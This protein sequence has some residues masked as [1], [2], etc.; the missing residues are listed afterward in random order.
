M[1]LMS[2]LYPNYSV[3]TKNPQHLG[4]LYG[5]G[6]AKANLKLLPPLLLPA[7]MET[8]PYGLIIFIGYMDFSVTENSGQLLHI[9]RPTILLKLADWQVKRVL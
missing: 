4:Q 7:V 1:V 5:R 6:E 3:R 8:P 2:C 9:P